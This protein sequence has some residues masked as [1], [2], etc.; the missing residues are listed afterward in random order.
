MAS[1]VWAFVQM[2]Q[3]NLMAPLQKLPVAQLQALDSTH[4]Q[5]VVDF[6]NAIGQLYAPPG[7]FT[8]NAS[9]ALADRLADYYAAEN[10]L[11]PYMSD[12]PSERVSKLI[13]FCQQVVS[14][15]EPQLK[16]LQGSDGQDQALQLTATLET[17]AGTTGTSEVPLV[18]LVIV[19]IVG[20]VLMV[21][22]GVQEWKV[23][24]AYDTAHQWEMNMSGL[25]AHPEPLLPASPTLS[26]QVTVDLAA[27][28]GL[29]PAQ[30]Q[31][32]ND[33]IAQLTAEGYAVNQWEVEALLRAG[34]DKT[35]IL[36]ILKVLNDKRTNFYLKGAPY[37]SD[38]VDV[39]TAIFGYETQAATS[40]LRFLKAALDHRKP[41]QRV[42][43]IIPDYDLLPKSVQR[44]LLMKPTDPWYLA[45][46]GTAVEDLAEQRIQQLPGF[47]QFAKQYGLVFNAP[48]PGHPNLIPD[49]QFTLPN[50]CRVVIDF[51]SF[52][53]VNT[54]Q[55]YNVKGVCYIVVV[56]H[57]Q[58]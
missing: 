45:D 33:I 16:D 50:G 13:Q 21:Q 31:E 17:T 37:T 9:D 53:Q 27:I 14:D 5:S 4:N 25:A 43:D 46:F 10:A 29:S 47:A 23:W 24:N 1:D 57:G 39:T 38:L 56:V 15:L 41:G 12:G 8:G 42:Q 30:Q 51:T 2:L 20:T 58:P 52:A 6:Q 54:K 34:Y 19:N 26:Q 40:N 32:V 55:K 3:Q 49:A 44:W 22:Q 18:Q 11:T 35:T 36:S 28:N 7:P 48:L